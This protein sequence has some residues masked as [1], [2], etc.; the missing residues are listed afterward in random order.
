MLT[1]ASMAKQ[2][3]LKPLML[4]YSETLGPEPTTFEQ[5]EKTDEIIVNT[6][7]EKINR[8]ISLNFFLNI[9]HRTTLKCDTP[10]GSEK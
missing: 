7:I 2:I 4:L 5:E 9:M 3:E 6:A 10:T 8:V 1:V